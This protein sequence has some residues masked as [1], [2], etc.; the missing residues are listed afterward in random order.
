MLIKVNNGSTINTDT[1]NIHIQSI[2]TIIDVMKKGIV[3]KDYESFIIENKNHFINYLKN[4][5]DCSLKASL[6]AS[7]QNLQTAFEPF[8]SS[9]TLMKNFVFAYFYA[10]K[11]DINI[12]LYDKWGDY[13]MKKI[14]NESHYLIFID[15]SPI[16]CDSIAKERNHDWDYIYSEKSGYILE[17]KDHF[18]END[19]YLESI[20]IDATDK[21]IGSPYYYG[22]ILG[23]KKTS[24]KYLLSEYFFEQEK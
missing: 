1:I 22:I 11:L 13:Y 15:E 12:K 6:I 16:L 23:K 7:F 2:D 14:D 8:R 10:K 17:I 18:I 5:N 4:L 24:K 19:Y 20:Y 3:E 9:S 21:I